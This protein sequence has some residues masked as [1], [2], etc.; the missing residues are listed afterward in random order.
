MTT[1]AG[2][3]DNAPK[4]EQVEIG[5]NV[6][7]LGELHEKYNKCLHA[8]EKHLAKYFKHPDKLP[9][10]RPMTRPMKED[11]E[12]LKDKVDAINYYLIKLRIYRDQISRTSAEYDTAN[13]SHT[14]KL[15]YGFVSYRNQ[16][17]AHITAKKANKKSGR[18]GGALVKLAP[19]PEDIIWK[20]ILLGKYE[21]ANKQWWGNLLFTVLMVAWIVPNAFIG[22]FLSDLSRIGVLWDNYQIFLDGHPTLFAILQGVLSPIVTSIIFLILPMIMRRMSQWQG[23]LTK[24]E[25]ERD[26]AN[27]LYA[28]FFFNNFFVFT[29]M[30][31]IW[32]VVSQVIQY[33]GSDNHNMSF[34]QVFNKLQIGEQIATA[35][36]NASSFWVMY[37]LKANLGAVLDLLQVFTLFWN[38]FQKRFLSPTPRELMLLTAPQSFNFS[39]YYIWVLFYSTIALAFTSI[40]PIIFPML[41]F[42]LWFDIILKKYS[43]M[44]MFVTKA[45]S[46][47]MFWPFIV[48]RLLFAL[49]VGNIIL[50]AVVWIQGGLALGMAV[51]PLPFIVIAFKIYL[52]KKLNPLFFY[53]IP[54]ENEREAMNHYNGASDSGTIIGSELNTR[55]RNPIVYRRLPQPMVRAEIRPRLKSVCDVNDDI[56]N[57]DDGVP[58]LGRDSVSA[59]SQEFEYIGEN[60]LDYEQYIQRTEEPL[61]ALDDE[62]I[63]T[64]TTGQPYSSNEQKLHPEPVAVELQPYG[65]TSHAATNVDAGLMPYA[66]YG[67]S[68]EPLYPQPYNPYNQSQEY[69]NPYTSHNANNSH[70]NLTT[71]PSYTSGE[72]VNTSGGVLQDDHD[73]RYGGE[74][75]NVRLLR[76]P[77]Q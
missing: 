8:L 32:N 72:Q 68:E 13:R 15:P 38:S 11:R 3:A 40:Q 34:I 47:G 30:S 57:G 51:V 42:Y 74:D 70:V 43:L 49:G 41:T 35:I 63:P 18:V 50:L 31:V 75:D 65:S 56:F 36:I 20:N 76:N 60:E 62:D 59:V 14:E 27:K 28:F 1:F 66:P 61:D 17:E 39:V 64:A 55:Y 71:Y 53:F 19:R 73:D 77:Y 4:V 6:R 21:R 16:P 45:E 9:S 46:D 37:I 29:M 22:C 5:H 12:K 52:H 48:N 24:N 10:K 33:V 69:L 7:H 67:E 25:R 58:V 2:T 26:V 54:T 23:K 44:Y